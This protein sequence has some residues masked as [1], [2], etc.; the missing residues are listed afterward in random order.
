MVFVSVISHGGGSR[1][2]VLQYKLNQPVTARNLYPHND[3]DAPKSGPCVT[4]SGSCRALNTWN[5]PIIYTNKKYHMFN[6]LYKRGS[7]LQTQDMLHGIA[8]NITGPYK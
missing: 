3:S 1:C 7:L 5:G 8:T 6:P 4:P 2:G